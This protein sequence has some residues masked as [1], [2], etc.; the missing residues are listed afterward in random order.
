[1]NCFQIMAVKVSE[2]ESTS[3]KV[4]EVLTKYGCYVRTRLGLH[5]P[6][7][8]GAC[9]PHGILIL[10]LCS[11]EKISR[12]LKDRLCSIEGVRAELINLA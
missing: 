2:R 6:E 11:E 12:E 1:M 8:D 9:S 4:Q 10:Q 5:A 3:L 7:S